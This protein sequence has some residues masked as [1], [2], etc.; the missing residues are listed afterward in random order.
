MVEDNTRYYWSKDGN[1]LYHHQK[2]IRIES[3]SDETRG[4]YQCWLEV[5]LKS[6]PVRLDVVGTPLILQA[7]PLIYIGEP[8]TLRCHTFASYN[9]STNTTFFKDKMMIHFS[10]DDNELH[11]PSVN[12]SVAGSYSCSQ[13]I[14]LHE[15]YKMF[16]AK[17][18][19]SVQE[20]PHTNLGGKSSTLPWILV[21]SFLLLLSTV[22]LI[23]RSRHKL[24]HCCCHQKFT[25]TESGRRCSE[26]DVDM[27][28]TSVDINHLKRVSA[29]H[30]PDT[31]DYSIIYSLVTE[32]PSA[33]S[34]VEGR[35]ITFTTL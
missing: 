28:Y 3:A 22:L 19:V 5:G 31:H 21:V 18:T 14:F 34:E 29:T 32:A 26:E 4:T 7:P 12:Q 33:V 17:T 1:L 20:K 8:L 9:I 2:N 10:V 25:I 11:F 35:R 30:R 6:D 16:S 23:F 27:Y 15:K 24:G 13:Q